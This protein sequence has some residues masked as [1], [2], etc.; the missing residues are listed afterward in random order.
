MALENYDVP[1][2]TSYSYSDRKKKASVNTPCHEYEDMMEKWELPMALMGGT[3]EMREDGRK[4]LPQEPKETNGAYENRLSRTVLYNAYR[5]TIQVLTGL[6]FVRAVIIDQVPSELEYLEQDC[7]SDDSDITDFAYSLLK[8][9]ID[10]G[11]SHVYVDMPRVDGTVTLA[12]RE[13]YKIRPYFAHICPANLISWDVAKIGGRNVLSRIRLKEEVYE[14]DG[15]WGQNEIEQIHVVYPDR[16]EIWREEKKDEWFLYDEYPNE[17]GYI[18]LVTIY[19]NKTGFLT[20]EPPLEDLAWLNLRHYQKLSDLDNIEHVA[21][22][23][24]LFGAGF[25]KGELEGAEIG[26]NRAISCS[27][28]NSKLNYVEHSGNAIAASQKSIK[29]LEERMASLGSDLIIRKSVDRQTAAARKIDQSESISLLQLMINNV[30]TG[31]EVAYKIAGD[32]IDI[33]VSDVSVTI[34]D[35]LDTS[36]SSSPNLYD[37]LI[38]RLID[39]GSITSEQIVAEL[40]RRGVLSDRFKVEESENNV[41][42]ESQEV[43]LPNEEEPTGE[44]PQ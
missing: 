39:E 18:P 7:D 23:P 37:I 12:D 8:D 6:P 13:L 42:N 43:D 17:L 33:D 34:G 32:W 29:D 31:I 30:E 24:I 26:P 44:M 4:W 25:E 11:K 36:D 35:N 19:G 14:S 21:N 3:H 20:A 15:E 28:E 1:G 16:H 10:F 27:K 41:E 22:V 9:C 40:K 5:R 2:R 38:Q